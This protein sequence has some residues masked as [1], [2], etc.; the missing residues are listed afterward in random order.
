MISQQAIAM[1]RYSDSAEERD[2]I[3]CFLV[4]HEIG[5]EQSTSTKSNDR[6]MGIWAT[7]PI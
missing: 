6:A 3:Y 4:F 1:A 5:D 7:R 2:R